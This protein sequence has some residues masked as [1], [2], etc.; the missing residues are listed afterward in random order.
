MNTGA[1]LVFVYGTLKRGERNHEAYCSGALAVEEAVVR[2]RLYDL[3]AGYPALIVLE[4]DVRAVGTTDPLRDAAV[5]NR[6]SAVGA[7]PAGDPAVF[8]ELLAFDDPEIRLPALDALEEFVPGDP[9]SP[10]RRVLIPT[11]AEND[12]IRLAWSYVANEASGRHLP[13]GRWP[14]TERPR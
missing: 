14:G 4:E 10:Y 2:G 6:H 8:G 12:T 5:G 11:F 7:G 1:I 13:S 9:S 3:T